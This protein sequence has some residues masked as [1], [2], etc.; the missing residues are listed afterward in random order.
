MIITSEIVWFMI[1]AVLGSIIEKRF[2]ESQFKINKSL[3]N[4]SS[5]ERPLEK[6]FRSRVIWLCYLFGVFFTYHSLILLLI[7]LEV[8][9]GTSSLSSFYIII[10]SLGFIPVLLIFIAMSIFIKR[11]ALK[12][13]LLLGILMT[14]IILLTPVIIFGYVYWGLG[15]VR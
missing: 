15:S 7:L 4:Q 6:Y 12:W 10:S 9:P 3:T 13:I 8:V 2:F 11:M 14:S 1:G 5:D